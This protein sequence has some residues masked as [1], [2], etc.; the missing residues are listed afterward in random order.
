MGRNRMAFWPGPVLLPDLYWPVLLSAT[1]MLGYFLER[2]SRKW[3][4]SVARL[5]RGRRGDERRLVTKLK[6][7]EY[8][9]R[10]KASRI[11]RAVFWFQAARESPLRNGLL[12]TSGGEETSLEDDVTHRLWY[13]NEF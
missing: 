7:S 5:W 6:L 12:T 13:T 9:D 2:R 8:L 3:H 1:Y 11:S 4:S 10:W